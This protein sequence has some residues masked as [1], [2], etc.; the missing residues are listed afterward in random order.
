MLKV[1][2]ADPVGK[3]ARIAV[4]TDGIGVEKGL[5]TKKRTAKAL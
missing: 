4:Q 2:S 3:F 5:L 1:V